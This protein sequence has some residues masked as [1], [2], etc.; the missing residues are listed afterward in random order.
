MRRHI[1]NKIQEGTCLLSKEPKTKATKAK[2][3]K[4]TPQPTPLPSSQNDALT[5]LGLTSEASTTQIKQKY[6]DLASEF[7]HDKL[8]ENYTNE[9][10]LH[11]EERFKKI[12]TAW[13]ILKTA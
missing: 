12:S 7:H 3:T 10:R 5:V 13:E 4:T 11:S 8:P 9:Q 6:H 1:S 2:K